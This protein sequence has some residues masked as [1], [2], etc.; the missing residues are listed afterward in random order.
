M[1]IFHESHKMPSMTLAVREPRAWSLPLNYQ[2]STFSLRQRT[3]KYFADDFKTDNTSIHF[4]NTCLNT[5]DIVR[6][7]A[8]TGIVNRCSRHI[9]VAE[10]VVRVK[11]TC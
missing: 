11:L 7:S 4:L 1:K 6:V 10:E 9:C 5:P 2:H 3:V 8:K